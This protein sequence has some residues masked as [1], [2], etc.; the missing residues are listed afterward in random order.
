M[1]DI[2]SLFT[3]KHDSITVSFVAVDLGKL[4]PIVY[5]ACTDTGHCGRVGHSESQR[6]YPG[7]D[8]Y[9][10]VAV[11]KHG[12][13]CAT[14]NE[15]VSS[16][17]AASHVVGTQ[18]NLPQVIANECFVAPAL[19]PARLPTPISRPVTTDVPTQN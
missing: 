4:P 10:P 2:V 13:L 6:C 16:V 18:P 15:T 19:R 3:C 1:K 14:L 9:S 11:T 7:C 5:A 8:M 17:E 12:G